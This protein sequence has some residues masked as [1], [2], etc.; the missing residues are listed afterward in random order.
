MQQVMLD[1]I[2]QFGYLGVA[3]LIAIEN[4]FPPI[5]SEVILTFGGFL[6]TV[7]EMSVVGVILASTLGAVIGALA[8]YALGRALNAERLER[9]FDSKLARQLRLKRED[10]ARAEAWFGKHGSKTVFLCRFIPIVRSLISIPAGS[11][12]MKMRAFLPLTVAGTLIWNAVLILL[13]RAA[14]S[15]WESMASNIDAYTSVG[16]WLVGGLAVVTLGVFF[17]RRLMRERRKRMAQ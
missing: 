10:V 17:G 4:L 9:W 14:G 5:P 15:A 7:S 2:N 3:L 8:L 16:G 11:S 12:G 1:I 6:T 13:G